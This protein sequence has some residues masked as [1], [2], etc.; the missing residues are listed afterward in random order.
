MKNTQ[1]DSEYTILTLQ[2]AVKTSDVA[3]AT[4][5]L[6]K[7]LSE[8]IKNN[9]NATEYRFSNNVHSPEVELVANHTEE[10]IF[11]KQYLVCITDDSDNAET[12]RVTT[13]V[14]LLQLEDEHLTNALCNC[15][16]IDPEYA[17]KLQFQIFEESTVKNFNLVEDD[18]T[19]NFIIDFSDDENLCHRC[20]CYTLED[21]EFEAE[22]A[23]PSNEIKSVK[24]EK[25]TKN[26]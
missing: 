9:D 6:N 11:P 10:S 7:T 8:H 26:L 25:K 19:S 1:P 21:A 4:E 20:S 3:E 5:S 12:F 2:V 14:A 17:H 24:M 16:D 23:Y 15:M 18:L 13:N 22:V